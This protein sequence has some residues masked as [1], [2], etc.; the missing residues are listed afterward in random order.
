MKLALKFLYTRDPPIS[1]KLESG[2]PLLEGG[3]V[4]FVTIFL[5]LHWTL[6]KSVSVKKWGQP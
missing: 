5:F 4:R 1:D 3:Y 6:L 2:R